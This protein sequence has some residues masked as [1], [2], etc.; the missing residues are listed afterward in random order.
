M[1]RISLIALALWL[2]ATSSVQAQ[3]MMMSQ[4][5]LSLP[6]VQD[7]PI[8]KPFS[9]QPDKIESNVEAATIVYPL[10]GYSIHRIEFTGLQAPTD[11]EIIWVPRDD[12][13]RW[14]TRSAQ[15]SI[16]S[17]DE[18]RFNWFFAPDNVPAKQIEVRSRSPIAGL[19]VSFSDKTWD[20]EGSCSAREL[21]PKLVSAGKRCKNSRNSTS[22]DAFLSLFSQLTKAEQCKRSYDFS[23]VP[24]IWVCDELQQSQVMQN[25]IDILKK[26]RKL[27]NRKAASFYRSQEF[28]G[29]LDGAFLEDYLNG[30]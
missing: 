19:T 28:R 17:S 27:G 11:L 29:T 12:V 15:V 22:C 13:E 2:F 6:V 30:R 21:C 1:N 25:S 9:P 24:G 14:G 18:C 23:P 26:L 16:K 8:E 5:Y 3:M 7:C 4:Q 10:N 20:H